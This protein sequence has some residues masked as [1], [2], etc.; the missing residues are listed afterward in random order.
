MKSSL[1]SALSA[2]TGLITAG[3]ALESFLGEIS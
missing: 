1:D 3:E 2:H